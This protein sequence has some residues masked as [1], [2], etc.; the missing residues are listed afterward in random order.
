VSSQFSNKEEGLHFFQSGRMPLITEAFH[1]FS[2]D[3]LHP[4]TKPLAADTT[5]EP[6]VGVLRS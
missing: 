2:P 4:D 5:R 3:K 6:S 1:S